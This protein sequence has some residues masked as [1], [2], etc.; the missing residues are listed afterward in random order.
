MSR[1][2][3]C[4]R[5]ISLL[6]L[7]LACIFLFAAVWTFAQHERADIYQQ[8]EDG[9]HIPVLAIPILAD[10]V[11]DPPLFF[12]PWRIREASRPPYVLN[13][14][15]TTPFSVVPGILFVNR[16]RT[17]LQFQVETYELPYTASTM[18][19][20]CVGLIFGCFFA[21]FGGELFGLITEVFCFEWGLR[22]GWIVPARDGYSAAAADDHEDEK[23][24]A[25]P[26]G[27]AVELTVDAND[28]VN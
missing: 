6:A 16:F 8:N 21:G 23:N 11:V 20:M 9:C 18:F 25:P 5:I 13:T 24:N 26:A 27:S 10:A 28:G 2:C 1:P 12:I 3:I 19:L 7:M 15:T 22:R 4:L 17:R 14:T